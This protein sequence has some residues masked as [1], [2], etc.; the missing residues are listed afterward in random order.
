MT[1][2]PHCVT[3]NTD[4]SEDSCP[5]IAGEPI[6]E[7]ELETFNMPAGSF[8]CPECFLLTTCASCDIGIGIAEYQPFKIWWD[9]ETE[10]P[11]FQCVDCDTRLNANATPE[12][13]HTATW[14]IR[15]PLAQT[16]KGTVQYFG[17]NAAGNHC[18]SVNITHPDTGD[19]FDIPS[20]MVG[21]LHE[22]STADYDPSFGWNF[23]WFDTAGAWIKHTDE[24][25]PGWFISA[26]ETLTD[27]FVPFGVVVDMSAVITSFEA[28]Q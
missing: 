26:D 17:R 21:T 11:C 28:H 5:L 3:C 1:T 8:L 12:T 19:Q 6:H 22:E 10:H 2:T 9:P 27:F 13:L 25:I 18:L 20:Y 4:N 7:L 24:G 14:T 15:T 23:D 16:L